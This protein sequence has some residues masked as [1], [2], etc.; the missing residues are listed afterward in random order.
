MKVVQF[1]AGSIGR[2]FLSPLYRHSG[3]EIVYVDIDDKLVSRL[4]QRQSYPLMLVDSNG[5]SSEQVIEGFRAVSAGD[6]EAVARELSDAD[7]AAVSVGAN[8]LLDTA[9]L[10]D[11]GIARR[12]EEAAKPLNILL[13][14]N[15]RRPSTLMRDRLKTRLKDGALRYAD[16]HIGLI[17][18]VVGRMVPKPTP[19]SLATDPLRIVAEP[20][21]ELLAARDSFK[22]EIPR[23]EGMQ[24]VEPLDA[25]FTR[26]LF[27]LNTTHAALAYLGYPK[28]QFIWQSLQDDPIHE[29]AA[30]ALGETS[31][32]LIA[33]FGFD[34]QEMDAYCQD[35]LRRLANPALGDTVERVA[36]GPLRKLSPDERLVG[37]ARLCER[38]G[39][40]PAALARVIDAALAYDNPADP[41]AKQM[42]RQ[43]KSFGRRRFLQEH[44][45]IEPHSKLAELLNDGT[46]R[47]QC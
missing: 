26:K 31:Q 4:N 44:C 33:E 32:A 27:T 42:Q 24:T 14:E 1:G 46:G 12:A 41:E 45:R 5:T 34:R 7:L 23:L 2:G 21:G 19:E 8:K 22:G 43:I 3:Y 40:A 25:Y 6:I 16:N 15:M 18:M 39:I 28:Y 10:L 38:H 17:D 29:T 13:C 35:I 11:A 30:A 47:K 37:A 20:H 36:A 9:P